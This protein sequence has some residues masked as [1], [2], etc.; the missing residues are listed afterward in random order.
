MGEIFLNYVTGNVLILKTYEEFIQ[1][2]DQQAP[3]HP[4]KQWTKDLNKHLSKDVKM[5]NRYMKRCS[6]LLVI[7]EMKNKTTKYPT[8]V[9]I[10]N[11]QAK[12]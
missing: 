4:I 7:R 11:I 10:A 3:N 9:R 12:T 5:D 2:S 6:I 1:F 8:P